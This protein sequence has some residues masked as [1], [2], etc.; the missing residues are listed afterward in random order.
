M[1]VAY[2][3]ET[4][5]LDASGEP[6][7]SEKVGDGGGMFRIELLASGSCAQKAFVEDFSL[8]NPFFRPVHVWSL[9]TSSLL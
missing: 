2:L 8:R 9:P 3:V 5:Y 1:V 7:G 6:V 4:I